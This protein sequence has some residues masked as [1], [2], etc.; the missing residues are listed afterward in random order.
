MRI[1]NGCTFSSWLPQLAVGAMLPPGTLATYRRLLQMEEA[2][3]AT[4]TEELLVEKPETGVSLAQILG[5]ANT[6]P[7]PPPFTQPSPGITSLIILFFYII[8]I[9][10]KLFKI[11]RGTYVEEEPVF[12]KY[13]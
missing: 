12:L 11:H 4:T 1:I 8:G 9:S 7:P 3:A 6:F 2:T 10:W 5:E 13:K